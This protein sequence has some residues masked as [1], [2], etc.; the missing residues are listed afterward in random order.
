MSFTLISSKEKE[1]CVLEFDKNNSWARV[2]RNFRTEFS[3]QPLDRH[4]IQKWHAKFKD[5]GYLWSQ[6]QLPH[7]LQLKQLSEF[8]TSSSAAT[9]SQSEKLVVS[10]RCAQQPFGE[11]KKNA[12]K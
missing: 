2:Q 7:H 10:F 8:V 9:D 1:F 3:K 6:K 5:E 12:C 4:T 11:W